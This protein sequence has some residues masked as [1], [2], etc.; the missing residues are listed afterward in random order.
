MLFPGTISIGGELK[1]GSRAEPLLEG[2]GRSIDTLARRMVLIPRRRR[3]LSGPPVKTKAVSGLILLYGTLNQAT[4][5]TTSPDVGATR[6]VAPDPDG[7]LQWH[8][9]FAMF[10]TV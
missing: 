6:I 9:N 7:E 10:R 5:W 3:P 4:R 2:H 8:G 1:C